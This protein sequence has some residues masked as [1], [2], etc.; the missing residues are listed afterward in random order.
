MIRKFI[1]LKKI[2]SITVALSLLLSVV[3]PGIFAS[4]EDIKQTSLFEKN[5]IINSK[6]GEVTDFVDTGSNITVIN[7]QDLHCHIQTQ[8][9]ITNILK[10]IDKNM[11]IN[12]LFIEGGYDN[13]NFDLINNIK[14]KNFRIKIID[15]MLADGI[16]TGAEYYA[17]TNNKENLL[18]GIDDK[19][20]H[21]ENISRLSQIIN[22][23]ENY[24]E[25]LK[26]ISEEIKILSNKYLNKKNIKFSK[27]INRYKDGNISTRKFYKIL[28]EHAKASNE[29][30]N[31]DNILPLFTADYP[32]ISNYLNLTETNSDINIKILSIQFQMFVSKLKKELTY[33]QYKQ[34]TADTD[35]FSDISVLADFITKY[36]EQKNINL[37]KNFSELNK[38]VKDI[39]LKQNINPS[40]LLMEEEK[41]INAVRLS[42]SD[43]NTEYEISY[44]ADFFGYFKRYLNYELTAYQWQHFEKNFKTFRK[45]YS[46]YSVIDRTKDIETDFDLINTYYNVNEKRNSIFLEKILNNVK[47]A[48]YNV[49]ST[50]NNKDIGL[51]CEQSSLSMT[52]GK[53]KVI[54]VVAG[55]FHSRELK[56]ELTANKINSITIMPKITT[57]IDS[58]KTEYENYVKVQNKMLSQAL[59]LRIAASAPLIEQKQIIVKTAIEL[60]P[61]VTTENIKYLEQILNIKIENFDETRYVIHFDNNSE[62]TIDS[63]ETNP[64]E[65]KKINTI[66]NN[67]NSI[68]TTTLKML[69]TKG[70]KSVFYPNIYSIVKNI[71]LAFFNFNVYFS[72][73]I[74]PEIINTKLKE[75]AID[76]I[77]LEAYSTFIPEVQRMLLER[78]Q[79]KKIGRLDDWMIGNNKSPQQVQDNSEEVTPR[80]QNDGNGNEIF[81]EIKRRIDNDIFTQITFVCLGNVNRSAVAD[82]LLN[83]MLKEHKKKNIFVSSAGINVFVNAGKPLE[84]KYK[85]LLFKKKNIDISSLNSFRSRRFSKMHISSDYII[86]ADEIVKREILKQYPEIENKI[87]L[88]KDIVPD[89]KNPDSAIDLSSD[90]FSPQELIDILTKFFNNFFKKAK[91]IFSLF[92]NRT[93]NTDNF[94][95]ETVTTEEKPKKRFVQHKTKLNKSLKMKIPQEIVDALHLDD[96][97]PFF[98]TMLTNNKLIVSKTEEQLGELVKIFVDIS[99][100]TSYSGRHKA[101]LRVYPKTYDFTLQKGNFVNAKIHYRPEILRTPLTQE[102]MDDVTL[103]YDIT[104]AEELRKAE[105][106]E[107][108]TE[109]ARDKIGKNMEQATENYNE[110][111]DWE[112]KG[113]ISPGLFAPSIDNHIMTRIYR[114]SVEAGYRIAASFD[115]IKNFSDTKP[116][117]NILANE[118]NSRYLLSVIKSKKFALEYELTAF[119]YLKKM[120]FPVSDEIENYLKNR[121]ITYMQYHLNK[122]DSFIQN[123]FDLRAVA[124]GIFLLEDHFVK[125]EQDKCEIYKKISQSIFVKKGKKGIANAGMFFVSSHPLTIAHEIGHNI[126]YSYDFYSG[127]NKEATTIH[128]LFADV[129]A[130]CFGFELGIE[131]NVAGNIL[132]GLFDDTTG[133]EIFQDEHRASRGFINLLKARSETL[134]QK[135]VSWQD[136]S[137][138]ILEYIRTSE[139]KKNTG[140]IKNQKEIL[141]NLFSGYFERLYNKKVISRKELGK[142]TKFLADNKSAF[143]LIKELFDDLSKYYFRDYIDILNILRDQIP[144]PSSYWKENR[145]KR[146]SSFT[147]F[148]SQTSQKEIDDFISSVILAQPERKKQ[149]IKI[150]EDRLLSKKAFNS[151][152]IASLFFLDTLEN[153]SSLLTEKDISSEIEKI[154]EF[155]PRKRGYTADDYYHISDYIYLMQN[156]IVGEILDEIKTTHPADHSQILAQ[157]KREVYFSLN[158]NYNPDISLYNKAYTILTIIKNN[159]L[160]KYYFVNED[161]VTLLIL[162]LLLNYTNDFLFNKKYLA[163]VIFYL[164]DETKV[165]SKFSYTKDEY[166]RLLSFCKFNDLLSADYRIKIL[167]FIGI[168]DFQKQQ[169]IISAWE[170]PQIIL[171]MFFP[172]IRERFKKQHSQDVEEKLSTLENDT[173]AKI[174]EVFNLSVNEIKEF[175]FFNKMAAIAKILTDRSIRLFNRT[176]HMQLNGVDNKYINDVNFDKDIRNNLLLTLFASAFIFVISGFN[177]IAFIFTIYPINSMINGI[178]SF[179]KQNSKMIFNETPYESKYFSNIPET[180]YDYSKG[181]MDVTIQIPV[182]T[183]EN[184]V[185]FET[186]RQSLKSATKYK[187]KSGAKANVLISEDGLAV[188]LDGNISKEHIEE[189]IAKDTSQLTDKEKQAVER[190]KFYRENNINFVARPKENRAGKFKKA[191]NLNHSYRTINKLNN[192]EKIEDGTYFEGEELNIYDLI[193]MLDK[194]SQMHEDVISVTVP[195]FMKDENLA[196]TQNLTYPSNYND[197]YLTKTIAVFTAFL[198]QTTF[199]IN[200]I[201]GGMVPFIGHN[202][203]IRTA[204]LKKI[205]Y[206][207]ENSVSEDFYTSIKFFSLGYRGKFLSFADYKFKEIVSRSYLE[208]GS[209]IFRYTFGIFELIFSKDKKERIFTD[210]IKLFIKSKHTT[211]YQKINF[212][213]YPLMYIS[214][215]AIIPLSIISVFS[216]NIAPQIFLIP[217]LVFFNEINT[218][219]KKTTIIPQKDNNIK[220]ALINIFTIGFMYSSFS[221]TALSGV[222]GFFFNYKNLHFPATNV[223]KENYNLKESS[224]KILQAFKQGTFLLASLAFAPIIFLIA[225][226]NLSFPNILIPLYSIYSPVITTAVLSPFFMNSVK[227]ELKKLFNKKKK[228]TE[229]EIDV[230]FRDFDEFEIYENHTNFTPTKYME[231]FIAEY[232]GFF[233]EKNLINTGLKVNGNII[234]QVKNA[235]NK[236]IFVADNATIKEI[237]ETLNG[238]KKLNKKIKRAAKAK[239]N[240]DLRINSFISKNGEMLSLEDKNM[241]RASSGIVMENMKT[242]IDT[243]CYIEMLSAA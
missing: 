60:L 172:T 44:I 173:A 42:L 228:E 11:Q 175:S 178:W 192:G 34:L 91:N 94:E 238:Y 124:T 200:A 226:N 80:S 59:A 227:D 149:I 69:P 56:D 5:T 30:Q 53:K 208:E 40:Q 193:L 181:A 75:P 186:I 153:K 158:D 63:K 119:M 189:L 24:S 132:Y 230:I 241:T 206:W 52:D 159:M 102:E 212:F 104:E 83:S 15:R 35:N 47:Y 176:R 168:R 180:D 174:K 123:N 160:Q 26:N 73:G 223:D 131:R 143:S 148:T 65:Q 133:E 70:F 117:L 183:E 150:I 92:P 156:S 89:I 9:N 185:I 195:K 243:S 48:M 82:I 31:F 6:Y 76:G 87:I 187:E 114:I 17:L 88:F 51:P 121:F 77:S 209:K 28:L 220:N 219:Y 137:D 122:K 161:V 57:E 154:A 7:I 81:E 233:K 205:G 36:C 242:S 50:T 90:R 115:T 106:E 222:F 19:K 100:D 170:Y 224:Q 118:N 78:Q 164:I 225:K 18:N 45:L 86:A 199:A 64:A 162:E 109:T 134:L 20:L 235:G 234:W 221:Y 97:K 184:D 113:K 37:N 22:K 130:N 10:D 101:M 211:W 213:V 135:D 43:D 218:I 79:K 99:K 141:E 236:L 112:Q 71:S 85:N 182:Y 38:F 4:E 14:D 171:G 103:L 177:P 214:I 210:W 163:E 204:P 16:L 2:L 139:Y 58:A 179:F 201:S 67:I 96:G 125:K 62:I 138:T 84:E 169:E 229:K 194:D 8:Q 136:L 145:E 13:I 107:T 61:K 116:Y 72:D 140:K 66:K 21:G 152:I 95:E 232:T 110:D 25:I 144:V 41:L 46:K 32:N 207:P 190:I 126:L 29:K 129:F 216:G 237:A 127:T 198:Y 155:L 146:Q 197:N 74:I 217:S 39:K 23:K 54:V 98:I 165:T 120:R 105:S 49:Q 93:D 151:R 202:G 191:S 157:I 239:R 240:A 215:I 188:L 55:G 108:A 27:I 167:N 111:N 231:I 166:L 196:Y 128:E 203:F 12:T 147:R 142:I 1:N 3:S 33:K 68:L